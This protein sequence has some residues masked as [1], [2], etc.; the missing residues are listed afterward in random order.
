MLRLQTCPPEKI[1]NA[2]YVAVFCF[3]N[4][5]KTV[6]SFLYR[7]IDKSLSQAR[8]DGFTGKAGQT[9]LIDPRLKHVARYIFVGLGRESEATLDTVR[10]GVAALVK[11]VSTLNVTSV[12]LRAPV[13]GSPFEIGQAVSE[14]ALLG[15]YRYTG[16]RTSLDP[17]PK[18]Q[19]LFCVAKNSNES[20]A[21]TNGLRQGVIFAN[22]VC[23]ARDWINRP[24][25]DATPSYLI[26]Q[27]KKLG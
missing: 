20:E 22:A 19:T 7:D 25:S 8:L 11:R 17:A 12:Y 27:A 5:K 2:A 3:E 16:F 14:G 13:L 4:A 10:R 18:L 21:L 24:P 6:G 1:S 15:L 23:A 9:S 26:Q